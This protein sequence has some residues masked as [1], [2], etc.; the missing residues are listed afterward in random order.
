MSKKAGLENKEERLL[1]ILCESKTVND[2]Q[3][4]T[5]LDQTNSTIIT[6]KIDSHGKAEKVS[7]LKM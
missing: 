2:E 3:I 5:F 6:I 1:D 7:E 4:L